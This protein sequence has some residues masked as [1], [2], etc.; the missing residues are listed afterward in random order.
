MTWTWQSAG[1]EQEMVLHLGVFVGFAD[2]FILSVFLLSSAVRD[3]VRAA[4]RAVVRA[5]VRAEG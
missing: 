1:A 3:G 4:V 2:F 5:A